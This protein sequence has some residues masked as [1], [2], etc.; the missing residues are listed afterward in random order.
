[1]IKVGRDYSLLQ[2]PFSLVICFAY[3]FAYH[4]ASLVAAGLTC[5]KRLDP[6]EPDDDLA[7]KCCN[8][9]FDVIAKDFCDF[10]EI[11]IQE[12]S[13]S[14][15]PGAIPRSLNLILTHDMCNKVNPGDEVKAIG[16]LMR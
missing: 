14:L 9:K 16:I 4:F 15:R 1:M 11:K 5:D 6:S 7:R 2:Q 8:D 10:Q 13:S 3:R 12:S